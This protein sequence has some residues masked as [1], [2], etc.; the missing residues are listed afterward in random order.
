MNLLL[1]AF[2]VWFSYDVWVEN[3]LVT[4]IRLSWISP[5]VSLASLAV[6]L[7]RALSSLSKAATKALL[8][9]LS[10]D[11]P[12]SRYDELWKY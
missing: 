5:K 1:I 6:Y 9:A 12:C 4:R 10:G 3:E 7:L 11:P 2:L 8:T